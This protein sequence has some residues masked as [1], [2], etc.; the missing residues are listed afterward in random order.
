MDD[1]GPGY[2]DDPD[3]TGAIAVIIGRFE[4]YGCE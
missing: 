4:V 1:L 3:G 2:F